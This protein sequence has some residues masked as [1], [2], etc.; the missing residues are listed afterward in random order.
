MESKSEL[1]R[2]HNRFR[3]A[4][5]FVSFPTGREGLW[6]HV[7]LTTGEKADGTIPND[8]MVDFRKEL[9]FMP[10]CKRGTYWG[11]EITIPRCFLQ[12]VVLKGKMERR[13]IE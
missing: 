10:R 11:E 6:I 4:G 7:V 1:F 3:E 9:T 12:S 5:E 2:G 8:L 13:P